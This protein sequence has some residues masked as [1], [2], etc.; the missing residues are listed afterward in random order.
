MTE[1]QAEREARN[2][3]GDRAYAEFVGRPLLNMPWYVVGVDLKQK[4]CGTSFEKAFADADDSNG[5]H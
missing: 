3:W 4:G 1:E 5:I 2:R